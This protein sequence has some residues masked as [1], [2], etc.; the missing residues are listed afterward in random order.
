MYK[1]GEMKVPKTQLKTVKYFNEDSIKYRYEFYPNKEVALYLYETAQSTNS[2][3]VKV[4]EHCDIKIN[5]YTDKNSMYKY[6]AVN[7]RQLTNNLK[8]LKNS[9]SYRNVWAVTSNLLMFHAAR[10]SM[11]R[12]SSFSFKKD[13]ITRC[14]KVVDY[15]N[16]STSRKCGWQIPIRITSPVTYID[17]KKVLTR[18]DVNKG[19]GISIAISKRETVL[20]IPKQP[21]GI[22]M[23]SLDMPT[24]IDSDQP[25]LNIED[26]DSKNYITALEYDPELDSYFLV[27]SQT[28]LVVPEIL[29]DFIPGIDKPISRE[30]LEAYRLDSKC[31]FKLNSHKKGLQTKYR[32]EMIMGMD[33]RMTAL[34]RVV[35]M[36]N[37]Q[38]IDKDGFIV[39]IPK[40]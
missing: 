36:K 13:G 16:L 17:T 9:Q 25:P 33:N 29:Y 34:S 4:L 24:Y 6:A 7:G 1:K 10:Q 20:F 19:P 18:S 40:Q 12:L 3:Y 26:L 38:V 37:G 31:G 27:I 15:Y 11:V 21:Y 32:R 30:D 14:R 23:D 28:D 2:F 8:T 22:P 39:L 35:G 5:Q